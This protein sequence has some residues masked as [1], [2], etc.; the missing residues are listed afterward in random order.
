MCLLLSFQ[1]E[2]YHFFLKEYYYLPLFRPLSS[3]KKCPTFSEH[4]DVPSK[5]KKRERNAASHLTHKKLIKKGMNPGC[6]IQSRNS[7]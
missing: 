4:G 7:F 3:L 1:L 5:K 2:L 6:E